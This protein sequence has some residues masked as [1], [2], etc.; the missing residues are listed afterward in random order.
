MCRA[1]FRHSRCLGIT[2]LRP[3]GR[4][5]EHLLPS[6][7]LPPV[8]SEVWS[9]FECCFLPSLLG[10]SRDPSLVGHPSGAPSPLGPH[11]HL[12]L[13]RSP[14][15]T[16]SPSC[17]LLTSLLPPS[18][19]RGLGR[20]CVRNLN[21]ALPQCAPRTHVDRRHTSRLTPD[22]H[23]H[24]PGHSTDDGIRSPTAKRVRPASITLPVSRFVKKKET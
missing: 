13:P 20:F 5:P 9:F 16:L 1:F 8:P 19:S 14:C 12:D 17:P 2:S 3:P 24:P 10:T 11:D 18:P 23:L 22:S 6:V 21:L 4:P 7:N 15:L